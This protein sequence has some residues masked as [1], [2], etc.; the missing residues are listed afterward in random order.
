MG[1]GIFHT[2]AGDFGSTQIAFDFVIQ[3]NDSAFRF[4]R[5]DDTVNDSALVIHGDVV[6]EWI[7]FKLFDAQGNTFTFN[8]DSQNDSFQFVAFLEVVNSGFTSFG[9]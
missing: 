4:N 3:L 2:I 6:V 8:V 5:F 7:A 1:T 9:P